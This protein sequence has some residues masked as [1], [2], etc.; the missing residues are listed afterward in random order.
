M[1]KNNFT[2]KRCSAYLHMKRNSGES[3]MQNSNGKQHSHGTRISYPMPCKRGKTKRLGSVPRHLYL[4]Y[5]SWRQTTYRSKTLSVHNERTLG[6][7]EEQILC[8]HWETTRN[9]EREGTLPASALAALNYSKTNSQLPCLCAF[10]SYTVVTPHVLRLCTHSHGHQ[11]STPNVRHIP[12]HP[13]CH[14][15]GGR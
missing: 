8:E 11:R 14:F 5:A 10:I 13:P 15:E 12:C 4:L 6:N 9:N 1:L 3:D 2:V 7:M